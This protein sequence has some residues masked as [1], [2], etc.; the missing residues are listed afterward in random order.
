MAYWIDRG[1]AFLGR[2]VVLTLP[3]R[4]RGVRMRALLADGSLYETRTRPATFTRAVGA[5][6]RHL[7][8]VAWRN[9]PNATRR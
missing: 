9:D 1:R 4:S 6:L 7:E 2:E 3:L 5:G 8:G